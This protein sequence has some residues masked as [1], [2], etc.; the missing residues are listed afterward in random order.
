[1]Y[2]YVERPHLLDQCNPMKQPIQLASNNQAYQAADVKF[3]V[4]QSLW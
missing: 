4:H 1:M 2:D 3:A